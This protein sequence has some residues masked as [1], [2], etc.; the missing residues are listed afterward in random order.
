MSVIHNHIK[1]SYRGIIKPANIKWAR[2]F[3]RHHKRRYMSG[4]RA[5]RKSRHITCQLK[6]QWDTIPQAQP[7][8]EFKPPA[9]LRV[10]A[11]L[12]FHTAHVRMAAPLWNHSGSFL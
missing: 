1:S 3:K 12:E 9:S 6:P 2:D 5:H 4:K 8:L 11:D 10:S 7:E